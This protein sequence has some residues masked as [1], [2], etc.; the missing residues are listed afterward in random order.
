MK[1]LLDSLI[2]AAPEED[3]GA[4]KI[5]IQIA[6]APYAGAVRRSQTYEGLYE[7]LSVGMSQHNTPLSVLIIFKPEAVS[8]VMLPQEELSSVL[9]PADKNGRIVMPGGKH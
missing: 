9:R 8:A 3:E 2:D 7:L 1:E 4:V 5:Q 6:S